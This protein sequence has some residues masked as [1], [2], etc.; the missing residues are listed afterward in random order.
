MIK[1]EPSGFEK[2][3]A[4]KVCP[5]PELVKLAN[6]KEARGEPVYNFSVGNPSLEPPQ[7]IL[8]ELVNLLKDTMDK[9]KSGMF[10]YSHPAGILELREFIAKE[11]GEWQLGAGVGVTGGGGG[12][13]GGGDKLV[14]SLEN[15]VVTPGAQSAIVNVFEALLEPGDHAL[16]QTPF[17][18][19]YDTSAEL[20]GAETKKIKFVEKTFDVDVEHLKE[21]AASSKEKLRMIVLCSPSNPSRKILRKETLKCICDVVEKDSRKYGRDVWIVMDNTYWRLVFSDGDGDGM[22]I[23]MMSMRVYAQYFLFTNN[24]Y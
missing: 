9:S 8:E 22:V 21:V 1:I 17:Y 18:P 3:G 11:I 12:G 14:V 13:G 5:M 19:P 10:K 7:E 4:L 6:E 2:R 23:V 20:W 16:I 15:I 24:L